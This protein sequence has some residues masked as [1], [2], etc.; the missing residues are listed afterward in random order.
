VRCVAHR[1]LSGRRLRH[2]QGIRK[3]TWQ[4]LTELPA[5]GRP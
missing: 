3:L 2:G 5:S 1:F 4:T